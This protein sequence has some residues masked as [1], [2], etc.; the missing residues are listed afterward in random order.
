MLRYPLRL[1]TIQ[2][3]QRCARVMAHAELVRRRHQYL[4]DALSMGFWVGSSGSPN[5]HSTP[6]VAS[7]PTVDDVSPD[8]R[9][10]EVLRER[11]Q[12]Y[13]A[14]WRAWNKLPSCPFCGEGTAL[15]R[16]PARGGTLAHVCSSPKCASNGGTWQPLPFYICDDDIYDLAPSV[17]LGTVDKLALIGHSAPTIRRIM[18]MFG[19]APWLWGAWAGAIG[20]DVPPPAPPMWITLRVTHI[21]PGWTTAAQLSTV[22]LASLARI[23]F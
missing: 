12:R 21:K 13:S 19:M 14:A 23:P 9:S 3:A 18:G 1:L 22:R 10:E 11:D 20:S 15:R 5:R 4:G 8:N 2:Q 16:F 6:G 7:I 17:L